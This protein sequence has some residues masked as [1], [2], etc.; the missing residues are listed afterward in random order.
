MTPSELTAT[1]VA[2]LQATPDPRLRQL[3]TSLIRHLH[4]FVAD[5]A[6]TQDEWLAAIRFLTATGQISSDRRQEFILL[7]DTL[8][9]SM[10]VDL[11]AGPSGAGAAGFA[12]ESTVLGPFYV[13]GSPERAV[14]RVHRRAPVR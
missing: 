2:R 7:S 3:M 1:V 14:W 6:L 11:I 10:L 13:P 8:G 9:A 4:G 5:V 12:T